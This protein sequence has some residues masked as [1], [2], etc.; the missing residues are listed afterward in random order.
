MVPTT[1]APTM[2]PTTVPTKAPITPIP[3]KAPATIGPTP[4]PTHPPTTSAQT[5]APTVAPATGAC[6]NPEFCQAQPC[7]DLREGTEHHS[8]LWLT[9]AGTAH[10][11]YRQ[12]TN[13]D[14]RTW[15]CTCSTCTG[16]VGVWS[17]PGLYGSQI[18]IT[19]STNPSNDFTPDRTN[20]WIQ[21]CHPPTTSPAPAF[22]A[23]TESTGRCRDATGGDKY[24][25]FCLCGAMATLSMDPPP[26]KNPMY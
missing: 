23:V 25:G 18:S 17:C 14:G 22:T 11:E 1:E 21:I 10:V 8:Y 24:G 7:F 19:S 13:P 2:T 16:L 4:A 3:T 15:S 12:G 9:G 6:A 20:D 5:A 26:Y